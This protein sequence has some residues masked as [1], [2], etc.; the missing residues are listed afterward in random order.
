MKKSKFK[1]I[2][3]M[4]LATVMILSMNV[5]AFASTG[6]EKTKSTETTTNLSNIIITDNGVYLKGV[7][8]SK[9]QFEALLEKA[10]RVDTTN[11]V[12]TRV[13]VAAVVYFIPG[14]GEVAIAGTAI[15]LAGYGAVEV[16]SWLYDT[17][18]NYLEN[19]NNRKIA[20]IRA[21][22]PSRLLDD[23][24]NVDLGEFDQ[25]VKGKTSYKEKGGWTIDKD[26][27]GHGNR[28]WK[29]KDKSG[30]RVASLGENGEV[31]AN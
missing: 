22:I 16:G 14:I 10:E 27:A 24:G 1:R 25:N 2:L 26:K 7:Y 5:T 20:K 6:I 18:S 9:T 4:L 28:K 13:A 15:V 23:D 19:S 8:Y 3:S 29:L 12:G 11:S 17:I 31:L 30:N 21:K